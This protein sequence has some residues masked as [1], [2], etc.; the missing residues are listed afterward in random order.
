M[1][2]EI[3][4]G[5]RALDD[6]LALNPMG[7][8]DCFE[9]Q[10]DVLKRDPVREGTRATFPYPGTMRFDFE[11]VGSSGRYD[12]RAFF[13]YKENERD[14]RIYHVAVDGPFGDG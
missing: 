7:I 9:E 2:Y 4:W 11:C 6:V 8:L 12:F 1:G 3:V 13:Y 14:I 10:M 5:Y